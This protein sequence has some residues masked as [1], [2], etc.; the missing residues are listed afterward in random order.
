MDPIQARRGPYR[1][2]YNAR[3]FGDGVTD[4]IREEEFKTWD[5]TCAYMRSLLVDGYEITGV[6]FC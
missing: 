1:V 4:D 6:E 3:I 5:E 2:T